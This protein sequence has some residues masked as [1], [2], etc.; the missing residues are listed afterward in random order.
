MTDQQLDVL[1]Q[2]LSKLNGQEPLV[3]A[4]FH[5]IV[6]TQTYLGWKTA[7]DSNLRRVELSKMWGP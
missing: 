5:A 1:K 4:F 6:A 7:I 3:D 2:G